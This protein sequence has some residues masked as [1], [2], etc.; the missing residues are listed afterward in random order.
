[1]SL[2]NARILMIIAHFE[3]R[4]EEYEIP[5]KLF[6]EAGAKVTVASSSTH[7]A[8][9]RFGLKVK[10]D[11][12]ISE[13]HL[14]NFDAVVFVGGPGIQ[15]FINDG[16]IIRLIQEAFHNRIL[17]AAICAAPGLLANAG[18]L[19][20]KKV[21]ADRAEKAHIESAGGYYT[22]RMV[23][24]DGEIITAMG[25]EAAKEFGQA[26]V[27]AVEWRSSRKGYLV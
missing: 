10:P 14:N 4:D 15:E 20:N 24:Q 8:H 13:I 5:R 1:M 7:E 19:A 26:I 9:G 2:E 18:I 21:T 23:E 6:D 16:A 27:K 3:F 22:G 17:L 11:I 12:T 25:P